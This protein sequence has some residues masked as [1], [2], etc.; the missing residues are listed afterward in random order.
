MLPFYMNT[1][2][3]LPHFLI[4]AETDVGVGDLVLMDN[5]TS[6]ISLLWVIQTL[7]CMSA[8]FWHIVCFIALA[9]RK[10]TL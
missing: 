4:S 10:T 6:D 3:F 8:S 7:N 1:V 9:S 2:A 5:Y